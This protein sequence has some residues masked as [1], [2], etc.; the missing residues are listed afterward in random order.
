MSLA[1]TTVIEHPEAL[2]PVIE[3][4]LDTIRPWMEA[5]GGNVRI[6]ELTTDGVLKLELAGACGTCPMSSMT[7][8]AGVEEAVR[9]AVPAIRAVEAI[10]SLN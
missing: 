8:K 5:D 4:A 2:L 10:N 9:K 3:E 6:V 7:M 1:E